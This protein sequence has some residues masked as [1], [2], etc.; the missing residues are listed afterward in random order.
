MRLLTTRPSLAVEFIFMVC[1]T[2]TMKYLWSIVEHNVIKGL[3]VLAIVDEFDGA[4]EV[5]IKLRN[6]VEHS[7]RLVS[8]GLYGII[9]DVHDS[10]F[11]MSGSS[12]SSCNMLGPSLSPLSGL[13]CTSKK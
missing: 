9:S 12:W 10:I 11:E 4:V 8:D 5:F 6:Q 13:G 3:N 7:L 1:F 2:V